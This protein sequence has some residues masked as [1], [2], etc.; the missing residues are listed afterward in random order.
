MAIT[1]LLHSPPRLD[2]CHADRGID[3]INDVILPPDDWMQP[4]SLMSP[5]ELFAMD[6]D[7]NNGIPT[8]IGA[9]KRKAV[10][11]NGA[12][13]NPRSKKTRSS[14]PALSPR[15]SVLAAAA[16]SIA[17][18]V[19]RSVSVNDT[20]DTPSPNSTIADIYEVAA[21]PAKSKT[22]PRRVV[23]IGHVPRSEFW[24]HPREGHHF[25]SG[26]KY[27]DAQIQSDLLSKRYWLLHHFQVP[28]ASTTDSEDSNSRPILR[29]DKEDIEDWI[30]DSDSFEMNR[31]HQRSL[32]RYP[33]EQLLV[34]ENNT[35][36]LLLVSAE[37]DKRVFGEVPTNQIVIACSL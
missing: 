16:V 13:A 28:T 2:R 17:S 21:P 20:R 37:D 32:T 33:L 35:K 34:S 3:V 30:I 24:K 12:K 19:N 14:S 26:N 15:R 27:T 6:Y 8:V 10:R 9:S 25:K 4:P 7:K 23:K 31:T 18:V 11:G 5:H 22:P 36:L 1:P 29:S